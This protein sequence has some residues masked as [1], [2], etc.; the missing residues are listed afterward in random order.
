MFSRNK[1][2]S[3]FVPF[4]RLPDGSD[5]K[6]DDLP[7]FIT[8]EEIRDYITKNSPALSKWLLEW[9]EHTEKDLIDEYLAGVGTPKFRSQ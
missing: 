4:E 5:K 7:R 2:A 6:R 8:T 9:K 1:V 3:V